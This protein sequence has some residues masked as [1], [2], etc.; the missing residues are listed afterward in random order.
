MNSSENEQN[1]SSASSTPAAPDAAAASTAAP[2]SLRSS[3]LQSLVRQGAAPKSAVFLPRRA[4]TGATPKAAAKPKLKSTFTFSPN[5]ARSVQPKSRP[6]AAAAAVSA[7]TDTSGA[8]GMSVQNLLAHQ[9]AVQGGGAPVVMRRPPPQASRVVSASLQNKMAQYENMRS[10][11][12][13]AN[14]SREILELSWPPAD[15]GEDVSLYTPISLPYVIRDTGDDE[16][17]VGT[18]NKA[19]DAKRKSQRPSIKNVDEA[20]RNAA[21]LFEHDEGGEDDMN[22][23]CLVQLPSLLPALNKEA[24]E[25]QKE[26]LEDE[27]LSPEELEEKRRSRPASERQRHTTGTHSGGGIGV[28]RSLEDKYIP[29]G[30]SGLPEGRLGTIQIRKSGKAQLVVGEHVFDVNLG[31]D[32]NFAQDVGCFIEGSSEFFFLGR[33]LKKMTVTPDVQRIIEKTRVSH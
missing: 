15:K 12:R 22:N 23:W 6:K 2:V 29:S 19:T 24:M 1:D 3:T 11:R 21:K 7:H 14:K 28:Q 25:K 17:I 20:N 33:C 26:Q 16:Q 4:A 30:F 10:K 27:L 9:L 31:S 8:G 18:S 5:V 13:N 32:C